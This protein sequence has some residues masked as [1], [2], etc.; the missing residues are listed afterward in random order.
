MQGSTVPHSQYESDE[1]SGVLNALDVQ[2]V[3]PHLALP[4]RAV[5][6]LFRLEMI[7]VSRSPAPLPNPFDSSLST[8]LFLLGVDAAALLVAPPRRSKC[9]C[10]VWVHQNIILVSTYVRPASPLHN[11][12]RA[13]HAQALV[14]AAHPPL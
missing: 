9:V 7:L 14:F 10:C 3:S 8:W 13:Q 1:L 12:Q 5:P 6:S 2:D 4:C 11:T